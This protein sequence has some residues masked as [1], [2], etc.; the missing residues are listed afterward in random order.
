MT[1]LTMTLLDISTS[2]LTLNTTIGPNLWEEVKDDPNAHGDR[3][4]YTVAHHHS[5]VVVDPVSN[6]ALQ[7][8]YAHLPADCPRWA[9]ACWLTSGSA[10]KST[11]IF[12]PYVRAF[13]L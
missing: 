4:D 3:F 6:A 10:P 9:S 5:L 8:L 7:W 12:S 11:V 13:I 1:D 2:S